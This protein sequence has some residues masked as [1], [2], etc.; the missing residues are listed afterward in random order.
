MNIEILDVFFGEGQSANYIVGAEIFKK[1]EDG[2]RGDKLDYTV[3]E[4]VKR[5][6][7]F[8]IKYSN[9]Q[10][11]IVKPLTYICKLN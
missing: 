3:S 11:Y 4:I 10:T 7:E 5:G 6:D 8:V 9:S 2:K 1:E